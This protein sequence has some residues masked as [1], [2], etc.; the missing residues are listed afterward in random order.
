MNNDQEHRRTWRMRWLHSVTEFAD[1]EKQRRLWLDRTNTNPHFSFVEYM[2]CYFD[3][4]DLCD[5][6]YDRAFKEGLVSEDE[7]AAVGHFHHLADTYDSPSDD[8]DNDAIL[9]DQNWAK[10]VEAAK[11]ARVALLRLI[12][13]P[14]ERRILSRP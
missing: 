2:C 6:G 11:V 1:D 14:E 7:V 12:Q 8:Y 9:A 13:D 5:D 3:D 10:V 4:L